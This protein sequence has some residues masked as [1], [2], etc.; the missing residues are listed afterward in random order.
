MFAEWF[1]SL[2]ATDQGR[3]EAAVEYLA[4]HGPAARRPVVGEI[5]GSR[6][7][8]LR[9]LRAGSL[10]VLFCF[11]PEQRAILLVG[12]DKAKAG[13]SDWYPAAITRAE[14]LY[15]AWRATDDRYRESIE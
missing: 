6:L 7:H 12:G 8:H 2:S 9:E 5:T 15:E 10:R 13:W 1:G 4:E 11:D 3:I 14:N